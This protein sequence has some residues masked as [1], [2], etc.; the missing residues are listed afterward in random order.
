M[1]A[2]Y[3]G[4][5]AITSATWEGPFALR[6]RFSSTYGTTYVYQV[7]SGRSLVG[8]TESSSDREIVC[9][10]A[11]SDWPQHITLLAVDPGQRYTDYGTRLPPRP[12]NQVKL[13]W[14]TSGWSPETR[15]CEIVAGTEP[16]GSVDTEN[17]VANVLFDTDRQYS[18]VTPPL[19][20]S[21][22]WSFEIAG[23]DDTLPEGNRGTPVSVTATIDAHPPDVEYQ[24]DD[25]SRFAAV[26]N[27]TNLVVTFTESE[28]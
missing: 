24:Q 22:E 12:Y 9:S 18:Y 13:L 4:G 26:A 23:R 6:V 19:S 7:Y 17:I 10:V 3:L 14:T 25:Y 1:T 8:S 28:L 21:G 16:G 15:F 2:P 11:P 27:G 5:I 20:G